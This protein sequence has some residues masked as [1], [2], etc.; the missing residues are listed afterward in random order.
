MAKKNFAFGMVD[1]SRAFAKLNRVSKKIKAK[2]E[3]TVKDLV[4][5]GKAYAQQ[6]VPFDTGQTYRAIRGRYQKDGSGLKGE[7]YIELQPREK[8]MRYTTHDIVAA[9]DDGFP[10]SAFKMSK[11]HIRT[12]S[13]NFWSNTEKKLQGMKGDVVRRNFNIKF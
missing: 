7:V 1:A 4:N 10:R 3:A 13:R 11:G 8:D 5:Y 12:G 9:M 6:Y 2:A